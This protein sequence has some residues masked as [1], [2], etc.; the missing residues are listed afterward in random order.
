MKMS[1]IIT[2]LLAGVLTV[3]MFCLP[4]AA[5]EQDT[6]KLNFDLKTYVKEEAV[7]TAK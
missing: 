6:L 7:N 2:C 5:A 3:S 4:V 1:K